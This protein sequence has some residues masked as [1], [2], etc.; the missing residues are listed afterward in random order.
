VRQLGCSL[1]RTCYASVIHK[2][3]MKAIKEAW[4]GKERL[5]LVFWG[6]YVLGGLGIGVL[7]GT[8]LGL[9][10][11]YG[12]QYLGIIFGILIFPYFIWSTW[13]V[14]ACAFNVHWKPLG[15]VARAI[16]ALSVIHWIYNLLI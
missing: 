15:Y 9:S 4:Y 16:V 8:T 13:S 6:Y 7:L 3:K 1:R 5:S 11:V 2:S 10:A 14:W 12:V